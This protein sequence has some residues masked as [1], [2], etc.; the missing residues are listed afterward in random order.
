LSAER[1]SVRN[2]SWGLA[3]AAIILV[4]LLMQAAFGSWRL[5]FA[6]LLALPLALV[7]GVLAA[8]VTGVGL[9]LGSLVGF[10]LVWCVAVRNGVL[11]IRRYQQLESEERLAGE[12]SDSFRLRLVLRGTQERVTPIVMTAAVIAVMLAPMLLLGSVAGAETF[13]PIAVV[14]LGGLVTST[15]LSL[16][17]VPLL[18]LLFGSSRDR[19]ER[20]SVMSAGELRRLWA[21]LRDL[22]SS[23]R[24]LSTRAST[25]REWGRRAMTRVSWATVGRR[26]FMI[27]AVAVLALVINGVSSLAFKDT[28]A[29]EAETVAPGRVEHVDGTNLDRVVLTADAVKRLGIATQPVREKQKHKLVPYAAVLYDASGATWT[30]TNPEPLVFVRERVVVEVIQG[31]QAVL[32]QGPATGTPVVTVGASELYGTEF[33]V[34][35]DE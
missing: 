18:Y 28:S 23:Q 32:A 11:L 34:S 14:V 1:A 5:A 4:L 16:F 31:D 35:G 24:G 29:S 33:G 9:T 2:L 25:A 22:A 3:A 6:F 15:V 27:L 21:G 7:G 17:G 19:D 13:Y 30:Y 26:A 20:T 8:L 12:E 10:F